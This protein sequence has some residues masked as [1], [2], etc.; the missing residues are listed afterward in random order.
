[1][2]ELCRPFVVERDRRPTIREHAQK[3]STGI[4]H[5]LN[6]KHHAFFE[7]QF[8]IPRAIVLDRRRLVKPASNPMPHE[9][10]HDR[11]PAPLGKRL[12]LRTDIAQMRTRPHLRNP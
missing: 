12:N 4:D 9:I 11:K 10:A 7:P 1:M 2:L 3:E 6:R 8:R 5:R